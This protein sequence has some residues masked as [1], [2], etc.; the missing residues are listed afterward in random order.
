MLLNSFEYSIDP[1]VITSLS[2]EEHF[3][4]VNE[5]FKKNTGYTEKELIGKSPR[6]LQGQKT[7]RKVL[8]ELK[9]L[10]SQDKDFYGTTINYRKDGSEY[11]VYWYITAL[12]DKD[13]KKVAYIS[14]QKDITKPTYGKSR[15][16]LL[17]QALDKLGQMVSITDLN[18]FIIYANRAFCNKYG[19]SINELI[20]KKA[21]ILKSGKHDQNFYR[22]LWQTILKGKIY[23][24]VFINK[25]KDGSLIAEKKTI[26]PLRDENGNIYAFV[27]A[28]DDVTYLIKDLLSKKNIDPLTKLPNRQYLEEEIKR[29]LQTQDIFCLILIDL[30][31]FKF[32]N[33]TCGHDKGDFVLKEFTRIVQKQIRQEDLFVRW[34]GDEFFIVINKSIEYAQKVA[35]KILFALEN[36]LI[37][38]SKKITASIGIAQREL[39]DTYGSLFKKADLALYNSK[40]SGKNR[41]CSY[42]GL[43]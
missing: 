31:D 21:N 40:K 7:D 8:D 35:Q 1:V 17:S 38:E 27:N 32:I 15:L 9:S 4:Y 25:R 16:E 24:G 39:N 12:R 29:R 34:G 18:G 2:P 5:A 20:G 26:T 30:D 14:Y 36:E 19:Y 41:S 11:I 37:I 10:L 23:E 28:G 22:K 6:I 42:S 33:D 43:A 13:G 3:L